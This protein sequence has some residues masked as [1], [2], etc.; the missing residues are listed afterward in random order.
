MVCLGNI[1]RSPMAQGAL[2]YLADKTGIHLSVDSAGIKDWN[3]GQEPDL[4]AQ[5]IAQKRNWQIAGQRAR[6]IKVQDFNDFDQIYTME[7]KNI[8]DLRKIQPLNSKSTIQLLSDFPGSP[9]HEIPDPYY[10]GDFKNTA[11]LIEKACLRIIRKSK[12]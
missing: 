10:S 3:A 1:C 7:I 9:I 2:E 12:L 4:R 6:Q 11:D 5:L 8:S